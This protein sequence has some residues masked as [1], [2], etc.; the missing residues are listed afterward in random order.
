MHDNDGDGDDDDET[1]VMSHMAGF[2]ETL[3]EEEKR[4]GD[5]LCMTS[6]GDIPG[7]V[8]ASGP[9]PWWCISTMIQGNLAE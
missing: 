9:Y 8:A 5:R 3:R 7:F 4:R 2:S 1:Q 6:Q